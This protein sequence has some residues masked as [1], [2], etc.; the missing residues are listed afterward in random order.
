MLQT[1]VTFSVQELTCV[2]YRAK[3]TLEKKH[4]GPWAV[5]GVYKCDRQSFLADVIQRQHVRLIQLQRT[6][7]LLF[8]LHY[9][10]YRTRYVHHVNT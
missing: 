9:T 8:H 5:V 3:V 2:E 4:D 6:D 7:P 10:V 1:A